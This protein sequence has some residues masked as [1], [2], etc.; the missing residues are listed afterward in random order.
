MACRFFNLEQQ[1]HI[2]KEGYFLW[3]LQTGPDL[4]SCFAHSNVLCMT[5]LIEWAQNFRFI[6]FL[7]L[8]IYS[9]NIHKWLNCAV[10]LNFLLLFVCHFFLMPLL[11]DCHYLQTFQKTN[12]ECAE[13]IFF[14]ILTF[15]QSVFSFLNQTCC[16]ITTMASYNQHGFHVLWWWLPSCHGWFYKI[17]QK[18][19][20]F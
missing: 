20:N 5:A 18:Y 3:P 16:C 14:A 7:L 19:Q 17:K 13:S 9:V 11:S 6:N 15:I 4:L 12:I 8:N 2:C 10:F 1:T